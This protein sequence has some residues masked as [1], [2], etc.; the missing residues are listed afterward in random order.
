MTETRPRNE[1][2]ID[3][4]YSI[5]EAVQT[6]PYPPFDVARVLGLAGLDWPRGSG[7]FHGGKPREDMTAEDLDAADRELDAILG[8]LDGFLDSLRGLRIPVLKLYRVPPRG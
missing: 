7:D 8:K 1:V 5:C 3:A 2:I 6:N 4:I